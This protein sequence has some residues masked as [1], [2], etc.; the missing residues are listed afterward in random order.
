MKKRV[1]V[2][3]ALLAIAGS[4]VVAQDVAKTLQELK[5][6]I[7]KNTNEIQNL[8]KTVAEK[9]RVIAAQSAKIKALEGQTDKIA[10]INAKID[11]ITE[12]EK[13]A[14][15][16]VPRGE[17]GL[18]FGGQSSVYKQGGGF[19]MGG[20]YD[21]V[22]LA[23]DPILGNRLSGHIMATFSRQDRKY[24]LDPT[25]GPIGT[26]LGGIPPG[27]GNNDFLHREGVNVDVDTLSLILG[28]KYRIETLGRIKPY[29]AGGLGMYTF[30]MDV[31][32]NYVMG[33]MPAVPQL[34]TRG[35]PAGN[36][37]L[38]WGVN[39]GGGVEV[40]I[41]E[42]IGVGF[43]GRYNWTTGGK[44]TDF[45]TYCGFVSFNF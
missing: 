44:K 31:D 30:A 19:L 17:F 37:D 8:K 20:F 32:N 45:G 2:C 36:V 18:L 7:Q 39:F 9:D 33:Q 1:I 42:L 27:S 3:L 12:V 22:I 24:D 11:S 38:E 10:S 41:N 21:P 14:A 28:A 4:N 6:L 13:A 43:D 34:D 29:M 5:S 16:P 15:A 35:Y 40:Q 25:L 23:K 26:A